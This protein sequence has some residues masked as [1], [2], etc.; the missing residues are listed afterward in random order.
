MGST[1]PGD[2]LPARAGPGAI[3]SSPANQQNAGN[4]DSVAPRH[5]DKQQPSAE[6]QKEGVVQALPDIALIPMAGQPARDAD[7]ASSAQPF[8]KGGQMPS[9]QQ[10][11]Q[12]ISFTPETLEESQ[13]TI[14]WRSQAQGLHP[15][16]HSESLQLQQQQQQQPESI[17]QSP[18]PSARSAHPVA[19][20]NGSVV[21][22]DMS[23]LR[24][25]QP[26]QQ[27]GSAEFKSADASNGLPATSSRGV[28]EMGQGATTAK[29]SQTNSITS[30]SLAADAVH[31]EQPA[32]ND[33]VHIP[34][35]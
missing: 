19:A 31:R 6:Q 21:Q 12:Q 30:S 17:F 1:Q 3:R 13:P 35:P 15:A 18:L 28:L 34:H 4:A 25:G 24:K 2:D 16:S 32:T 14:A 10:L 5:H 27:T 33:Q 26:T 7:S 22:L 29:S 23:K 11:P 9:R 8:P 20:G